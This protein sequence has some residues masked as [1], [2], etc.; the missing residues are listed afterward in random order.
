ME[1]KGLANGSVPVPDP[2]DDDD[3]AEDA[4]LGPN[5]EA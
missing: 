1:D 5:G 2:D 4:A 3:D